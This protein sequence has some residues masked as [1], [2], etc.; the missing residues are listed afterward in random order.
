MEESW[1]LMSASTLHKTRL[2]D[3]SLPDIFPGYKIIE[4]KM[5]KLIPKSRKTR[6]KLSKTLAI[7]SEANLDAIP[8]PTT[9]SKER[10]RDLSEKFEALKHVSEHKTL[11]A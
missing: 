1:K 4:T 11:E 3:L 7:T 2:F 6:P 10:S 5:T 8:H 9:A